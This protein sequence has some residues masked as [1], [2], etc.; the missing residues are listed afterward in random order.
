MTSSKQQQHMQAAIDHVK[1]RL[2]LEHGGPFGACIVKDDQIIAMG[3]N[4]VLENND[5][6]CHAEVNAIREAC[7]KLG[8]HELDGCEIYSTT[9]PCPMCFSAI[10]WAGI[11]RII[12]GT[13]IAD[14]KALGFKELEI[15]NETMRSEGKSNVKI[16]TDFMRDECLDLLQA[17]KN[18]TSGT[19]Y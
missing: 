8:T 13:R 11:N 3:H 4:T 2:T 12:F 1:S 5:P 14:V 6:T 17:W 18:N 16:N 7:V 9:E 19:T 10:H 15:S